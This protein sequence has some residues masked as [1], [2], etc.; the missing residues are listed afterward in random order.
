LTDEEDRRLGIQSVEVAARILAAL[1]AAPAPVMLKTVAE[2]SGMPVAKVH[3]YL[4]S[5][6]RC[7][8]AVQDGAGGRYGVGPFAIQL[9][10][11]GLRQ[12]DAVRSAGEALPGLRDEINETVALAVWANRGPTVVRI[13]ESGQ[14][15]T[16]NMRA[17]SVL[18]LA[19]SAIGLGF[20]AFLPRTVTARVLDAERAE[21]GVPPDLD[22]RIASIAAAGVAVSDGLTL[23]GVA[24]LACP[25]FDHEGRVAAVIGVVGRQGGLDLRLDGKPARALRLVAAEVSG[26][27]GYAA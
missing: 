20:L 12:V 11:A 23:P 2:A 17:G 13:D 6:T 8:L 22:R 9:G 14:P 10:L 1:A 27:L 16:M 18:P 15:V 5:L 26:R 21:A 3:R 7:G 24:A 4:T 19:R 25:V